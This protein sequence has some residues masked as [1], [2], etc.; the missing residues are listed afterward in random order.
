MIAWLARLW[1]TLL[2]RRFGS[3]IWTASGARFWPLDPRASEII[4]EDIA[5]GLATECRFAGQI[6][7]GTGYVFYSVAE[8][9]VIVSIFMER[10]AR[11]L[12]L[13]RYVVFEWAL[14]GLLH[15]ATEA[16]IGDIA[17]PVK[18]R[19]ELRAYLK[20]EKRLDAAV[21]EAFNQR[22]TAQSLAVLHEIDNRIIVD[23]ADAFMQLPEGDTLESLV[24]THGEPLGCNI[25][26]LPPGQ[27]EH[28][29]L[30]RYEEIMRAF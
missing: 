2:G 24:A 7:L 12:G 17:R 23:E 4:I 30:K 15:D 5:R 8:H 26:G 11:E 19:R 14:L 20:I 9:S 25:A 13:S 10:R 3:Y 18:Y 27:A 28:V 6:G 16:W 22:P 21:R 1:C 29:F